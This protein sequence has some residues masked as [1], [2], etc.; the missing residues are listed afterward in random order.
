MLDSIIV[1][2]DSLNVSTKPLQSYGLLMGSLAMIAE[3]CISDADI[4]FCE[5]QLDDAQAHCDDQL[6]VCN[7]I[8]SAARSRKN[9][10][11][12]KR[13]HNVCFEDAMK[14]YLQ[15]AGYK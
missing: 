5:K 15:C 7:Q 6:K 13:A 4:A 1:C 14:E 3:M 2:I 11:L 8:A 12:C 9:R 10:T